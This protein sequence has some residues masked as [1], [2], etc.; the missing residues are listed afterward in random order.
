MHQQKLTL[1]CKSHKLYA[2]RLSDIYGVKTVSWTLGIGWWNVTGFVNRKD[3]WYNAVAKNSYSVVPGFLLLA[4][5][6]LVL[7]L[8]A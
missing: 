6:F 7:G 4:L 3:E 8:K 5:E 1:I 2:L